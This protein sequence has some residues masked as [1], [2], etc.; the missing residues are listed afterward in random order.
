MI[1]LPMWRWVLLAVSIVGIA[2]C[3]GREAGSPEEEGAGDSGGAGRTGGSDGSGIHGGGTLLDGAYVAAVDAGTGPSSASG[4]DAG[5]HLDACVNPD[6]CAAGSGDQWSGACFGNQVCPEA[7]FCLTTPPD[8]P[9]AGQC[10]PLPPACIGLGEG[11][12][13]C[14]GN[15]PEPSNCSCHDNDAGQ[16]ALWCY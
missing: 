11:T 16:A 13:S 8:E 14:L 15:Y 2:S 4:S 9:P 10:E 5:D 7:D 3:G 6:G 12:C 1:R